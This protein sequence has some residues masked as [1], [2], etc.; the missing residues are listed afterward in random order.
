M[1]FNDLAY[2][3]LS[4]LQISE[5]TYLKSIFAEDEVLDYKIIV[6]ELYHL[7]KWQDFIAY[8]TLGDVTKLGHVIHVLGDFNVDLLGYPDSNGTNLYLCFLFT[9]ASDVKTNACH[10]QKL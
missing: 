1:F 9:A 10:S 8:L 6:G 3:L 2:N 4:E 5:P 7:P